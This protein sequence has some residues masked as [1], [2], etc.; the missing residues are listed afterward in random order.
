MKKPI[1]VVD[2]DVGADTDPC[3]AVPVIEFRLKFVCLFDGQEMG[4]YELGGGV[5]V[6]FVS[7]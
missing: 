5:R 1:G 7:H 4:L 3:P 2:A 6:P